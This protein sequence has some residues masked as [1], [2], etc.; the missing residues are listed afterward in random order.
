MSLH[1]YLADFGLA[2]VIK[3]CSYGTR[4]TNKTAAGR[5]TPGF[6]APESIRGEQVTTKS[7]IYSLGCVFIELFSLRPIWPSDVS[8]YS[9]L[10]KVGG[11]ECPS[12]EGVPENILPLC[13]QCVAIESINRPTAEKVIAYL[14]DLWAWL[15]WLTLTIN[16]S[17]M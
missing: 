14:L 6:Q 11:G 2:R 8:T 1:V 3:N 17:S 4:G 13:K 10:F 15:W 5:G 7:D 9:I 16:S 12:L